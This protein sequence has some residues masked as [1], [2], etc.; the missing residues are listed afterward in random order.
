MRK[1]A[2]IGLTLLVLFLIAYAV[3]LEFDAASTNKTSHTIACEADPFTVAAAIE[4]IEQDANWLPQGSE[5]DSSLIDDRGEHRV[6]RI[7]NGYGTKN[8]VIFVRALPGI[9]NAKVTI[10]DE[11]E[12][13]IGDGV[14]HY[15]NRADGSFGARFAEALHENIDYIESFKNSALR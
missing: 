8:Y 13:Q 10:V 3:R 2:A 9:D 5:M 7:T 14:R 6:W 4:L 11:P 12:Y 1:A 15:L